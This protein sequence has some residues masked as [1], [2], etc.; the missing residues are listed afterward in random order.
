MYALLGLTFVFGALAMQY[1]APVFFIGLRMGI[2]SGLILGYLIFRRRD[3]KIKREDFLLFLILG[4]VHIFIPY[5]G[6][7]FALKHVSP[8][9]VSL[10]WSLGPFVTAFF[11]WFLFGER[12]TRIKFLG[13]LVGV[14]GFVPIILH[15]SVG[16]RQLNSFLHISTADLALFCIVI[17][18]AFA[19]NLFK[20][21]LQKGYKPLV[22]NGW[23]MLIGSVLAFMV[24]PFVEAWHPLPVTH[25]P[26]VLACA[27]VL[28]LIGG[29][30]CYNIYGYMLRYYT[31]TFL[32]LAG[33]IIPFFTALFQWVILGQSISWAFFASMCVITLGLVLFYKEELR[34]RYLQ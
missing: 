24:S 17:S 14:F 10:I 33:G 13:L 20:R 11:A 8:A 27:A 22:L 32:S 18:S 16:E 7:Y 23:A 1:A 4:I 25:W 19:W 2:T 34:P 9:K 29:I 5:V 26:I 31:T 21:L 6:E 12:L 30:I 15:E 3:F 28:V